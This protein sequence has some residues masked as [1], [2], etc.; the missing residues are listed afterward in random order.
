VT[1]FHNLDFDEALWD[2]RS[3]DSSGFIFTVTEPQAARISNASINDLLG[4]KPNNNWAAN[5][6]LG[7]N[8]SKLLASS[9]RLTI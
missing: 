4:Y 6:L 1:V 5:R 7:E 2:A 9:V 8:E 3:F